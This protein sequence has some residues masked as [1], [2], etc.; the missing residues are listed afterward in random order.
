MPS[1]KS[2]QNIFFFS[3]IFL[4]ILSLLWF[5]LLLLISGR[6]IK[7]PPQDNSSM[8]KTETDAD[9][10]LKECPDDLYFES[11][12]DKVKNNQA[13]INLLNNNCLW[14][15]KTDIFDVTE[16]GISEI[17]LTTTQA[18][19]ASC[20]AHIIYIFKGDELIFQRDGDDALVKRSK[21]STG[22]DFKTPLRKQ[23]EALCCPSEGVVTVY[24]YSPTKVTLNQFMILEER[25]EPYQQ[26]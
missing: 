2:S 11:L 21:N 7:Q 14:V 20:H 26:L 13:I 5:T 15:L 9:L 12:P 22:F 16:D 3:I 4:I 23:D 10:F 24:K 18:G 25:S 8:V 1:C 17:L 6:N 19:C